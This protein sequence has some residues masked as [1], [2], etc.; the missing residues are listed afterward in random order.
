MAKDVFVEM[1]ETGKPSERI[2]HEKGLV[3]VTDTKEIESVIESVLKENPQEVEKY[4]SGKDR[5]FGFFVGEVMKKT[6]GKANPALVNQIL[7]E[8]LSS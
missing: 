1:A 3:Q 7:K 5:V 8:K 6:K 2:I 4:R